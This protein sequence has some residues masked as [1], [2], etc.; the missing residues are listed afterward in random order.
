M[1]KLKINHLLLTSL[2]FEGGSWFGRINFSFL[3][4]DKYLTG[5][6]SFS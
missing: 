2:T 6:L 4:D 3:Q 5:I 1:E